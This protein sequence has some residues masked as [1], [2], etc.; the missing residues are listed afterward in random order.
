MTGWNWALVLV[1]LASGGALLWPVVRGSAGMGELSAAQAVQ[2]MNRDKAVIIDVS[3]DKEFAAAHIKSAKHVTL[4]EL[5]ARLPVEVKKKDA[6]LIFVCASGM[7]SR[8]AVMI[9]KRLGYDNAES[10]S[11]GMRAWSDAGLPVAKTEAVAA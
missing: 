11:G 2:R 6:Q 1:V 10:M 8:R 7:R 4:T 3:E 5:E 9:A